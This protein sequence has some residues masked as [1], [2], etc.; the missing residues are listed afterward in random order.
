M[1]NEALME[2]GKTVGKGREKRGYGRGVRE[3]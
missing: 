1:V 3:G 2:M